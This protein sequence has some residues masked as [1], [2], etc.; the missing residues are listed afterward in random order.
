KNV[1]LGIV[2]FCCVVTPNLKTIGGFGP[3][4]Y[5]LFF[6]LPDNTDS[7]FVAQP[8]VI[9]GFCAQDFELSTFYFQLK[10]SFPLISCANVRRCFVAGDPSPLRP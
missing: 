10:G 2:Y 8:A 3:F 1:L 6:G 4:F 7:W 5:A 9:E